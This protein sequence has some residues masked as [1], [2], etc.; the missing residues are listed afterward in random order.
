MYKDT[1]QTFFDNIVLYPNWD[2]QLDWKLFCYNEFGNYLLNAPVD[3][4]NIIDWS[5]CDQIWNKWPSKGIKYINSSIASAVAESVGLKLL[6]FNKVTDFINLFPGETTNKKLTSLCTLFDVQE[7]GYLD[8]I[9]EW[10]HR[11]IRRET[12]EH[13]YLWLSEGDIHKDFVWLF[14]DKKNKEVTVSFDRLVPFLAYKD[15]S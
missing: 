6:P 5:F 2:I 11:A 14:G 13:I 4:I 1:Y 9:N 3:N 15:I 8:T 7:S 10:Q 12:W